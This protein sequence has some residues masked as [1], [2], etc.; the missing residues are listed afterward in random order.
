M[1]LDNGRYIDGRLVTSSLGGNLKITGSLIG[2]PLVSGTVDLGKTVI[3]VP[4]RLPPS[5]AALDVQHKNAPAAVVAQDQALRPDTGGNSA[6]GL[7]LDVKVNAPE[8]IFVQ[9][10]GL[11]AELGGDLKLTGPVGAPKAIG[12]FTLRRGRMGLLGR[13]LDFS[14][15]TIS[16]AGS[17][18]PYLDF[19]ANS[20][21]SDATVTVKVTGRADDPAFSFTS[22]PAMP[23]DEVLARLVFGKAM[24]GLSP[25]QIA[26]LASAAASLAGVGGSTSLLDKLSAATGVDDIDVKTDDKTGQTSVAVGK[27]VNDKTYVTIEKGAGSG[28]GKATIDLDVGGGLKLRGQATDTGDTKGGIFYEKEY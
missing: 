6:G 28:T 8:K 25:L 27:Y 21:V 20:S 13:R 22:S 23:E 10:R 9:G 14:S 5:L 15:G 11:D 19:A 12:Q 18:V 4:D 24:S 17:L 3:T 16:F 7:N 1:K 2:S 26:Q